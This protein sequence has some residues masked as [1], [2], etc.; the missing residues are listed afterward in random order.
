MY[1]DLFLISGGKKTIFKRLSTHA[2]QIKIFAK[3]N[4][5]VKKTYQF[6]RKSIQ[7]ILRKKKKQ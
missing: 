4:V 6:R 1:A 2:Q 3:K 7:S 5:I